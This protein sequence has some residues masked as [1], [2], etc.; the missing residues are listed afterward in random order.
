MEYDVRFVFGRLPFEN[1]HKS[2]INC[3][4]KGLLPILYPNIEI[5]ERNKKLKYVIRDSGYGGT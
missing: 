2:L 5:K 4:H 3:V 1:M